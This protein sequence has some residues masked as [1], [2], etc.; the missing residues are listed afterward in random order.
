MSSKNSTEGGIMKNRAEKNKKNFFIRIITLILAIIL[1]SIASCM[2]VVLH[3]RTREQSDLQLKNTAYHK[4]DPQRDIGEKQ[5]KTECTSHYVYDIQYPQLNQEEIDQDIATMVDDIVNHFIENHKQNKPKNLDERPVLSID[6]ESYQATDQL[7]SILFTTTVSVKGEEIAKQY[8]GVSYQI[9]TKQKVGL[10]D[11]FQNQ[12]VDPLSTKLE[13]YFTRKNQYQNYLKDISLKPQLQNW[14]TESPQFVLTKENCKFIFNYN[15]IFPNEIGICTAVI[16][17]NELQDIMKPG[18]TTPTQPDQ[19]EENP[20]S[21]TSPEQPQPPTEAPKPDDT[22]PS[23]PPS[24]QPTKN[25]KPLLALTF[26]DGPKA[27]ST[28]RI[29]TLLEQNNAKATFFVVG[30]QAK[31]YPDTL[32]RAVNMGCEI[33]N[34]TMDHLTLTKQTPEVMISQVDQTNQIVKE[35]AGVSPRLVR[36]PGGAVNDTVKSTLSQPLVLWSVD[37]RDWKTRNAQATID[38]IRKNAAPGQIIL[39]HDIYSTTADACDTIIPELAK[40]YQLVT[41][42]ELFEAYGISMTGGKTYSQAE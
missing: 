29:L 22:P 18:L 20:S 31:Q 40:Q 16:P 9:S 28:E 7:A 13:R 10:T 41:V 11:I 3:Q 17:W 12:F 1:F 6:Y 32:R 24:N 14:L 21:G 42:S 2:A 33:G 4:V 26:D 30:P 23:Q 27:S 36:P 15:T 19:K 38:H 34:H 39:M 37:T 35:I 8:T 25:G 5:E